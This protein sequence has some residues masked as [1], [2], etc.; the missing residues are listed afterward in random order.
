MRPDVVDFHAFYGSHLGQVARRVIRKELR[1]L[2]PNVTGDSVLGLGYATPFLGLFREEAV[3]TI[4]LMPAGQG[5]MAWPNDGKRLVAITEEGELPLPDESI[6]RILLVHAIEFAEQT[7]PLMREVW[8]VLRPGGHLLALVPNRRSLWARVERT[9]FGHG[10][11][12]SGSQL[13]RLLRDSHFDPVRQEGALYLPPVQARLILR[14][15][16]LWQRLGQVLGKPFG[17]VVLVEAT[18]QVYGAR[19]VARRVRRRVLVPMPGPAIAA[20]ARTTLNNR[21]PEPEPR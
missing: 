5:V 12:F 11:P 17:G 14:T 13:T 18:K 7:E 3:R 10:R 6:D 8:R 19:P 4:A 15:N 9:P 1:A 20:G 16:Q 2:W 21:A